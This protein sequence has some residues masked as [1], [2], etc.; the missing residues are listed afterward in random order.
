MTLLPIS[1]RQLQ[2]LSLLFLGL[3]STIQA[4]EIES[5]EHI[6]Q[7]VKNYLAIHF[8]QDPN[9]AY[10]IGYLDTRLK[11][12]KCPSSLDVFQ[13][14]E[15]RR[16]GYSS[17]QVRCPGPKSWKIYVPVKIKRFA[18]VLVSK[19]TLARGHLISA[20]DVTT[21]R[22]DISRLNNGYF[23]QVND[24]KGLS[25]KRSLREG[26]IL[27][28]GMLERQRLIKRG[29]M[30]TILANTGSLAIRM[31]G[32]ALM[33]GRAGELIRVKNNNS[34][35]EIQATVVASGTVEISM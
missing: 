12:D 6:R 21:I 10:E 19:R 18:N 1:F 27:T 7:S 25:L 28:N 23:T 2:Y 31:K 17:L 35:R 8:E 30:V 33:D 32:I 24:I 22:A 9:T 20:S 5:I 14:N 4:R 34:K 13:A 26:R 29:E 11:L 15:T 16:T 3:S